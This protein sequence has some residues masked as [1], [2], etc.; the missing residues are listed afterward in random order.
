L[1]PSSTI[2]AIKLIKA[3][4]NLFNKNIEKKMRAK[5]LLLRFRRL[6]SNKIYISNGEFRH[7]NNKVI[8][9]LY[10]FNRQKY[11]YIFRLKNIYLKSFFKEEEFNNE[12]INILKLINIKGLLLLKDT[13]NNK[14]HLIKALNSINKEHNYIYTYN[15]INK[16]YKNLV[17]KS[18]RKIQLYYY[19]KQLLF[20]NNSK[21]NY[22]YLQFLNKYLEKIYNKNVEF[23]LVNLKRFYLNTDILS[24]SIALK[25]KK[26]RRNI[27]KYLNNL[28][29]KVKVNKN[30]IDKT[31][32][33]EY[34]NIKNNRV[35]D[36][37]FNKKLLGDLK[38]KYITGFRLEANG[39]LTRRYTA[40]RS[41]SKLIYKGNLLNTDPSYKGLSSVSL[42][43]NLKSNIQYTKLNSKS[44]IGSFGIKG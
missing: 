22:T 9:T 21:F 36:N 12:L 10:V 16:F 13:N 39:R 24:E 28:K 35:N 37:T 26:N 20:I 6:S 17:K 3:Y 43:G 34:A 4:F 40:S 41:V 29:N 27:L 44:R 31:L 11:N 38:Y 1:I 25:I 18:L 14:Y 8:I 30:S 7:S 5:R 42:R 2:S 19:Y 32:I 23:N 15:Y 33:G